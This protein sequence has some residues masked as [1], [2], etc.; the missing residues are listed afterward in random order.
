M[1]LMFEGVTN[2]RNA[3]EVSEAD[4]KAQKQWETTGTI[5][6]DYLTRTLGD[7][8]KA[9][10]VGRNSESSIRVTKTEPKKT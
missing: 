7:Q 4:L 10:A 6:T 2:M 1:K 5:S 3:A 9:V 8:T